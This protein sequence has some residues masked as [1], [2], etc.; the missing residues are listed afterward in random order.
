M[1]KVLVNAAAAKFGGARTIIDSFVSS[2]SP[3]DGNY[4][5]IVAGYEFSKESLPDNIK[6]KYAP[7]SGFSSLFY[8]MIAVLFTYLSTRADY[9]ISFGNVNCILLG[10]KKKITYFHQLK[11]LDANKIEPKLYVYR[12]YLKWSS[13]P[14]VVQT[15]QVKERFQSMFGFRD[16]SIVVAWPGVN[17]PAKKKLSYQTSKYILVPVANPESVHKN[18]KFV[19]SLEK[20]LSPCCKIFVT[21]PEGSF[22]IKDSPGIEF[23]G[24]KS[25]EDLFDLYRAASCVLMPSTHETIGLPIFEA[26][27]LGTPVIAYD[28][29]YVRSLLKWFGISEGLFLSNSPVGAAEKIEE[30][31]NENSTAVSSQVDFCK[32]DWGKVFNLLKG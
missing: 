11:A 20:N 24:F 32:G 14:V 17:V 7:K 1:A 2:I 19:I 9:L 13:E 31:R 26:L 6:W 23:I 5:F 29:E 10:R 30:L 25:R 16:R 28:A 21:A 22:D 4:Y 8:S 12:L 18:F 3:N 15:F 27:A